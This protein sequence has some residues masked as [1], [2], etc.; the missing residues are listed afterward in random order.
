[1]SV[2]LMGYPVLS[3]FGEDFA[4][5]LADTGD[6]H[7]GQVQRGRQ[8]H[9]ERADAVADHVLQSGERRLRQACI[10]WQA[11]QRVEK[12]PAVYALPCQKFHQAFLLQT[13]ACVQYRRYHPVGVLGPRC[14]VVQYE[15]L[16]SSQFIRIPGEN[17]TLMS[18]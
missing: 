9:G 3:V 18:D 1:M 12:R 7:L 5:G 14:L 4:D 15:P 16:D 11:A 13:E 17:L 2:N 8:V 6:L 10:G